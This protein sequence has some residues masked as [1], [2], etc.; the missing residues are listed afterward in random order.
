MNLRQEIIYPVIDK[1]SGELNGRFTDT[2]MAVF[3]AIGALTQGTEGFLDRQTL[4][5]LAKHYKSHMNDFQIE[6]QQMRRMIE[7]KKA[8]QT[9]PSF[10]ED[11]LI[12]FSK[13]VSSYGDAFLQ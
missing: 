2:T 12:G 11:K 9:L 3:K 7:R 5:P 6:V 13:L 4:A 8:E 1:C 10:G